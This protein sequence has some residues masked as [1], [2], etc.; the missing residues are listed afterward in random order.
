MLLLLG[1]SHLAEGD[2]H[3]RYPGRIVFRASPI[4]DRIPIHI[5]NII[6]AMFQ[7][8]F[9]TS[10]AQVELKCSPL[11]V[12]TVNGDTRHIPAQCIPPVKDIPY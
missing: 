12:I 11:I 2:L 7:V 6:P 3:F 9:L 1:I 4:P 10:R 5:P 8:H